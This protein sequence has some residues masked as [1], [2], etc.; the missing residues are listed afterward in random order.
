[1]LK[2]TRVDFTCL[3]YYV[4]CKGNHE[5]V[6][7]KFY[8]ESYLKKIVLRHTLK[9]HK[10][11]L[12]PISSRKI[13]R[14]HGRWRFEKAATASLFSRPA[15]YITRSLFDPRHDKSSCSSDD[16]RGCRRRNWLF[17][18]LVFKPGHVVA[19]KKGRS[20]AWNSITRSASCIHRRLIATASSFLLLYTW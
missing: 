19:R 3:T 1:M 12:K 10:Q 7:I 16:Q 5:F 14:K 9:F 13:R 17:E 18:P 4:S 20:I 8:R 2:I 6:R 11:S 15:S